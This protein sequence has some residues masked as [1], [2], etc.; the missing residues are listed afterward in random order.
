MARGKKICLFVISTNSSNIDDIVLQFSTYDRSQFGMIINIYNEDSYE[1]LTL[2]NET[3]YPILYT[4]NPGIKTKVWL[5]VGLKEVEHYEY[6]WFMDDDMVFSNRIFPFRQFLHTVRVEDAVISSPKIVRENNAAS[7]HKGTFKEETLWSKFVEHT[8]YIEADSMMFKTAAW[9][10]FHDHILID[11]PNS[12]W[13]PACVWCNIFK[14]E[15]FGKTPC[16]RTLH[17]GLIHLDTQTLWGHRKV[18]NNYGANYAHQKAIIAYDKKVNQIYGNMTSLFA[19]T[20]KHCE[21]TYSHF[22]DFKKFFP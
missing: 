18:I 11:T 17:Y 15:I 10:F 3:E 2:S 5:A 6:V 19:Q 13:G 22:V 1:R 12:S 7:Q 4:F 20:W 9:V 14:V 16:V 21:I 8:D